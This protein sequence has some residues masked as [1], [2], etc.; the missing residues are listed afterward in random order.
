MGVVQFERDL[1]WKNIVKESKHLKGSFTKVGLFGNGGDA[2]TNMAERAA[3]HEFGTRKGNIPPR[4]FNR[5][6]WSR[7]KNEVIKLM[8]KKYNDILKTKGRATVKK[9]L[10][11]I[12]GF[13]EGKLKETITEGGFISLK[14]ATIARKGSTTPL[15]DT[16]DMRRRI[17]HREFIK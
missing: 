15:I 10:Q 5:R 2:S 17:T 11:D 8:D 4:P 14:P 7:H 9:A 12:G 16:G 3:V 6:A 13:F 1:G